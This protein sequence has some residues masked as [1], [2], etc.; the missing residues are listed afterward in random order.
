MATIK[1]SS[2]NVVMMSRPKMLRGLNQKV[3]SRITTA[4]PLA[5]DKGTGHEAGDGE[6]RETD[7]GHRLS[8]VPARTYLCFCTGLLTEAFNGPEPYAGKLACTV[9]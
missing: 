5:D 8:R 1:E 9:L 3:R 7:A 2:I 4:N 6:S